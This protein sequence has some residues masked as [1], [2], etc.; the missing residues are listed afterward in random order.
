MQ[1]TDKHTCPEHQDAH[2]ADQAYGYNPAGYNGPIF[3]GTQPSQQHYATN[4]INSS[5]G[6]RF[7]TGALIGVG[8]ALLLSNDTVQK[9]LMKG[10][11][12][13]FSAAQAGV[14]EIKEKFEDIRAEMDQ[15]AKSKTK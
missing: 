12:A 7:W 15:S 4:P 5:T 9:A 6:S 1:A 14:E 10:A 13:I 8:A 2:T 3:Y 11:T